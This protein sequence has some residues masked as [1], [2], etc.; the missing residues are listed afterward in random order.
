MPMP[1]AISPAP[2]FS[3][4]IRGPV[5]GVATPRAL[6]LSSGVPPSIADF[7]VIETIGVSRG[8]MVFEAE[9]V[10]TGTKLLM[11]SYALG[12]MD[13]QERYSVRRS[14]H[15]ASKMWHKNVA[16]FWLAWVSGYHT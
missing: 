6:A 12:E 2:A 5:T 10:A 11:K 13:E 7:V 4:Q 9:H 1:P 8:H 15:L 14:V 16:N 3:P